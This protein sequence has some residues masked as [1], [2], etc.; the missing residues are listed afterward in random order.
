MAPCKNYCSLGLVSSSLFP[1]CCAVKYSN[2]FWAEQ[3][4]KRRV[5]IKIHSFFAWNGTIVILRAKHAH[6]SSGIAVSI[7]SEQ[8]RRWFWVLDGLILGKNATKWGNNGRSNFRA[9]VIILCVMSW[10]SVIN[11]FDENNKQ[12]HTKQILAR[13]PFEIPMGWKRVRHKRAPDP[14]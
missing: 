4:R 7:L 8:R 1:V 5:A 6:N 9:L 2:S 13:I 12:L 11:F 10:M 3:K 14:I